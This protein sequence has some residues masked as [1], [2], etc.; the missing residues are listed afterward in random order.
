MAKK[1]GDAT[2][3]KAPKSVRAHTRYALPDGTAVP[4]VTTILCL[5]A[6]P[7]LIPW[8]NKLGLQGI[9]ST[10]YVDAKAKVGTCAHY[11]V[12]CH[13]K[14]EKPVLTEFSQFE[15]DQAENSFLKYLDWEKRHDVK[16]VGSELRLVSE[17]HRFGGTIDLIANVDGTLELVD[18]KTS[19]AIWPEHFYQL[20]AYAVLAREAGH[21]VAGHRIIR[22]G[23]DENEGFEDKLLQDLTAQEKIFMHLLAIYHLEA[24]IKKGAA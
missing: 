5:R 15:I 8:A 24:Q 12:E 9:D 13:L 19:G 23:R 3:E 10:K 11:L 14:G 2:K 21:K 4:G 18:F 1:T 22:I 16:P 17:A 6:K 20:S 7:K